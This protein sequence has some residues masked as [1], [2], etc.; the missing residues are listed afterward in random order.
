MRV[1]SNSTKKS[2][3]LLYPIS[4]YVCYGRFSA[5]HTA[6]QVTT[7]KITPPKTYNQA[8]EDERFRNA[9]GTEIVALEDNQ[10]WYIVD[11]PPKKRAI[12][13][14]WAYKV[15]YMADGTIERF[16]VRLVALE[17]K[18]V[19]GVDYKETFASVAKKKGR[20]VYSWMWLQNE[21]GMCKTHSCTKISQKKLI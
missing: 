15:K 8:V 21:A 20:S 18:Q 10:T 2:T 3:K 11:L 6:Y 1:L 13:G 7:G 17:N 4:K 19:E 16:K 5:R 9:M 14:K 12:R